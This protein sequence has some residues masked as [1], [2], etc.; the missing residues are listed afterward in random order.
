M[1]EFQSTTNK[2]GDVL[3]PY[4][5]YGYRYFRTGLGYCTIAVEHQKE[6]EPGM[7]QTGCNKQ[8]TSSNVVCRDPKPLQ[9]QRL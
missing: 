3:E 7:T 4:R 2:N 1:F 9:P 5:L 8:S 6:P